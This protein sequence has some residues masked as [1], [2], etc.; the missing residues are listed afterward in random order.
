[1]EGKKNCKICKK[2]LAKSIAFVV[3]LYLVK[4]GSRNYHNIF[5]CHHNSYLFH[6]EPALENQQLHIFH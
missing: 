1:M 6:T 2:K 5:G 4:V 3:E